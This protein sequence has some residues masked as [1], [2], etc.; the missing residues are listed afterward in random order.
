M[1]GIAN[2][3]IMS[4]LERQREFATLRAIGTSARQIRGIIFGESLCIG[5]M[6]VLLGLLGGV[7]LAVVLIEVINKQSFGWT[8]QF[9]LPWNILVEAVT[10]SCSVALLAG[11]LPARWASQRPVCEGLRYE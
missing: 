5:G 2:T 11:Y 7:L 3:L 10:V 6:G 9:M 8:I 4:V 1:L